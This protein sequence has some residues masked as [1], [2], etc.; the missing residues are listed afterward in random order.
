VD[1]R[2]Y[3]PKRRIYKGYQKDLTIEQ[4]QKPSRID[5]FLQKAMPKYFS[6]FF[7]KD[8]RDMLST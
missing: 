6:A 3:Q 2:N 4:Q 7:L 8:C 5:P 1:I